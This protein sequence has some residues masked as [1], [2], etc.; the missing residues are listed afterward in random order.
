M[1][2]RRKYKSR[3]GIYDAESN[4]E[5]V[6]PPSYPKSAVRSNQENHKDLPIR[7]N[8]YIANAG[9]CSRREADKLITSGQIK[10]N[11]KTIRELG[12]KVRPKDQVK[13]GNTILRK[14]KFIY[15]LLNKPKDHITTAKDPQR[16][17]TVMDLVNKQIEERIYPVGRLDRNTTGLL[18]LTN[19]G[20][21]TS[22][23]SHPSYNIRKIYEVHLDRALTNEDFLTIRS[24]I[25]LDDGPVK[26]DDIAILSE[27]KKSIGIELHSGRNRIVRRTFE[28]L[29]YRITGLD[30]VMYAFLTKK[31]LP[32]GK[33]R[34]LKDY[35]ITKLKHLGHGRKRTGKF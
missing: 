21:L 13:Y 11:G 17:N 16:R 4:A 19:D 1:K 6:N 18:L 20:E 28:Y 35:E 26:V 3:R 14:E 22:K 30:R 27:D 33:W 12:Y 31:N 2:P 23:L 5:K 8:K 29:N 32:R 9:I 7:L 24:G 10:V 25:M 15:I 34:F